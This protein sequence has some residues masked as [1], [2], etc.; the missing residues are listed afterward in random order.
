MP[1]IK[2]TEDGSHTLFSSDV[3]ECYH[4]QHG[5]IQESEHIFIKTGWEQCPKEEINI[6]EIGFGTGLNAFLTLLKAEKENKKVHYTALEYYPVENEL[7]EKLNYFEFLAEERK[8]DFLKLH[9]TLW[10]TQEKITSYFT[11]E[12]IR[13]DF[14]EYEPSDSY[15]LFYFDAFSPEK[16]PE[17]WEQKRFETLYAHANSDAVIVTYCSK[18]VVR[19]AM[20]VA[21]FK[22]ERLP[23]PPGKREIL[24]G[25]ASSK[26]SERG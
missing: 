5:A 24:R 23:G 8:P 21:G 10:N 11:L 12:K 16:Q 25:T 2:I 13:A 15:D 18:G 20:Q 22:V 26:L 17:M 6:L 9:A 7:V 4:S 14:T 1:V 19:R 3:D